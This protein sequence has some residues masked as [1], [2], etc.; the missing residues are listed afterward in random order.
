MFWFLARDISAYEHMSLE[1]SSLLLVG[2][3]AQPSSKPK[4]PAT[5]THTQTEPP[6]TSMRFL[7]ANALTTWRQSQNLGRYMI[8]RCTCLKQ[9]CQRAENGGWIGRGWISLF[10]GTPMRWDH[11]GGHMPSTLALKTGSLPHDTVDCHTSILLAP[12]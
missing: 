3:R 2:S 5:P 11:C 10:W 4:I 1:F 8:S 6:L 7:C 9:L 12:T